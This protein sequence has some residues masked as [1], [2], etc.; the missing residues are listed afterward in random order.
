MKT[1]LI[2]YGIYFTNGKYESHEIKIKNCMS[3][4]HAKIKL[5]EYL[6]KKYSNFKKLVVYS[7]TNNF[8]FENIF[9]DIFK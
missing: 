9:G 2:K 4:L 1:F 5:E 3:D 7:C 8:G 6:K